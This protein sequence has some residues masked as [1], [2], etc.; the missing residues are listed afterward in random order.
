MSKAFI[1][2]TED[3]PLDAEQPVPAAGYMTRRGHAALRAELEHLVKRERPALVEV[4]SW[5]AGNG[6]RSENGDYLYGKKRLREIDRRIRFL[7]KRLES[8]IVVDSAMQ[9]DLDRVYFGA[10]VTIQDIDDDTVRELQIVGLD[11]ADVT[12]GRISYVAPLAR[13]LIGAEVGE[14]VRFQAPTGWRAVDIL[15]IR[16][17]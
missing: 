16:Y 1:R 10:F 6:D 17:E 15:A 7:L 9:Q 5:A 2:E 13:A 12:M 8:A 3:D 4:V 14:Q 11:E